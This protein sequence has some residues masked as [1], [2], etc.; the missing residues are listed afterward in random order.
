MLVTDFQHYRRIPQFA[1][2]IRG[3]VSNVSFTA[4]MV[5]LVV[6]LEFRLIHLSSTDGKLAGTLSF[7]DL[8]VV[9]I[10]TLFWL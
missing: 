10:K 2:T 4:A 8:N 5:A 3:F 6:L 9:I 7:V 1:L